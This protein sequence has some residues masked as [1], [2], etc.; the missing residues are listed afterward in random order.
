MRIEVKVG[1]AGPRQWHVNL[2]ERLRRRHD[3]PEV[4]L[5]VHDGGGSL[6]SQALALLQLER[7][8]LNRHRD[9]LFDPATGPQESWSGRGGPPA[10][11]VVDCRG[12][13]ASPAVGDA[14]HH[15]RPLFDGHSTEEALVAAVLGGAMPSIDIEDTGRRRLVLS[16]RPGG[17]N[18]GLIG[19]L[20]AV[21]SR[22]VLLLERAVDDVAAGRGFSSPTDMRRPATGGAARSALSYAVHNLASQCAR[23]IFNLCFHSPHWRIGWRL[24]DGPGVMERGDLGG[25]R[26]SVLQDTGRGFFADPF[27]VTWQGRTVLFFEEYDY[28]VG[29]GTIS[30]VEFDSKGPTGASFPVLIEPWHQSYPFIV[31]HEGSLYMVPEASL[32]GTIPLYRCIDFPKRWER[33]GTLLEGVEASDCSLFRHDGLWWMTACTREGYGGYSDTLSIYHAETLQGVWTPHAQH[34]VLVDCAL[35]RP[36]GRVV[37]RNGKLWRPIQDCRRG[38]GKGLVLAEIETLDRDT[39]VQTV[40]AEIAPGE[41]WGGSRLHTLNRCGSLEVIDGATTVRRQPLG[42]LVPNL[43][44]VPEPA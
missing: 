13:L 16:G 18:S 6:P 9:T 42:A 43:W 39:F 34:P 40:R 29:R 35:A 30:G 23:A 3:R 11:I 36:A 25:P 28:R 15:L 8:L 5:S 19:G 17:G 7:V 24:H 26:W 2:A 41:H 37:T 44:Q 4:Q 22:T 12:I 27:P 38:Y 20:E 10:D 31:E 33:V 21:L 14:A 32:T 1:G